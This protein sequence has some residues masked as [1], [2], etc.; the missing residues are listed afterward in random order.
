[1]SHRH[2]LDHASEGDLV[3]TQPAAAARQALS[4]EALNLARGRQPN[5]SKSVEAPQ[6]GGATPSCLF[7]DA[8]LSGDKRPEAAAKNDVIRTHRYADGTTITDYANGDSVKTS[9]EGSKVTTKKDGTM[10]FQDRDGK[11]NMVVA[12]DGT[13]RQ[14]DHKKGTTTTEYPDGTVIIDERNGTKTRLNR[15]FLRAG[16]AP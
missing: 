8:G 5:P 12:R 3:G 9:S 1:M 16:K 14:F 10:I 4:Q 11:V 2:E 7:A 6:N 13:I 15:G